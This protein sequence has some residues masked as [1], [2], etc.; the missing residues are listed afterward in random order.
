MRSIKVSN[1]LDEK[2]RPYSAQSNVRALPFIGDG[3]KEVQRKALWG[4]FER[5]EN[6]Q[7]DSVERIAAYACSVTDYHHGAVSME[8]AIAKM[9][10]RY[11]GT[12]NFPF[13]TAEGQ[14][15]SRKNFE[16]SQARYIKTKLD[17]NF[18]HVFLKED[19][20]II[21]RLCNVDVEIEPKFF[22]PCMPLILCNGA[23]GIGTGHATEILPYNPKDIIWAIRE[24]LAGRELARHSLTPWFGETFKGK[25]EKDKLTGQV[26][27]TGVWEIYKKSRSHYLKITELPVTTQ[28]DN[29]KKML[30]DLEKNGIILD[31]DNLSDKN[32]FEF[33]IKITPE[34]AEWSDAQLIKTFKLVSRTTEN[35]TVW[36]PDG[37]ITRYE[38]VEDLLIDWVAWRLDQYAARFAKQI[39]ILTEDLQ[40]A[41]EKKQWIQLYLADPL[42]FRDNDQ[43]VIVSHMRSNGLINIDNLLSIP[44]R[45]L[46][47]IKIQELENQIL[48]I[49]NEIERIK[50]LDEVSVMLAD[51]KKINGVL[52]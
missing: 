30:D 41:R 11:A 29:Y 5:G 14:F 25:I 31:Y 47:K 24:I 22:I 32:G 36:N 37:K 48:K 45:S 18:R 33:I 51:L 12:N 7:S 50:N 8:E 10:K 6:R 46:T 39:I 13:L 38:C 9:A 1:F 2:L 16:P 43:A 42:F 15:G 40:W 49:T 44:M 52:N 21:E 28:G 27:V 19:D 34:M 4:I 26:E 23:D 17:E 3:M 20:C 35:C